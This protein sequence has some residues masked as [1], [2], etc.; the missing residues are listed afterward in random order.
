MKISIDSKAFINREVKSEIKNYAV[1]AAFLILIGFLSFMFS[2]RVDILGIEIVSCVSVI[3]GILVF[4][5]GSIYCSRRKDAFRKYLE[6]FSFAVEGAAKEAL[7]SF[8]DP[9]VIIS[10]DGVIQWCNKKFT[11]LCKEENI[12]GENIKRLLPSVRIETFVEDNIPVQDFSYDGR[13][14]ILNGTVSE[15]VFDGLGTKMIGISFEDIS[16]ITNLQK[17]IDDKRT[18]VCVASIDNYDEVL[19]ETPNSNHG[20]LLGDIERCVSLWVEKGGGIYRHYERDKYMI[21]FEAAKFDVLYKEK[22]T[23]LNEVKEINQQNKIPVTL[24]M[25]ISNVSDDIRENDRIAL[26]ALDMALGR[27]GDQVVMKTENGYSFF[28]AKSL[29]VE[30]ATKVKARIVAQRL[31]DLMDK[32]SNVIIM[33]HKGADYDSFGAAVGLF[34]AAREHGKAAYIAMDKNKNN[35]GGI[36]P[37]ILMHRTIAEGIVGLDKATAVADSD[38]LIIIVDTHRESMVEYSELFRFS[39]NIV[40]IDH[41]RRSED[42]M[43]NTVLTYHEPYASSTCEMVT[44]I[45][46]Y[47]D[48]AHDITVYEAEAMYCGIYM[49]TKAFKFKTGARTFEAAAYLRKA[50]VDP[51]R[52]HTLFRNDISMYIQKSKV[53]SNAKIYRNNIA[54]AVCDEQ[55]KNLQLV[56]AQAADDLL[57]IKGVEASFVLAAAGQRIIISGRSLGAV[58]VQV[59]LEKL[60]GGGHITI[61]GAQLE[62]NSLTIA[63][64][65]L[66]NAIDEALFE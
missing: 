61:A 15:E 42:F 3:S 63:E 66:H 50:G 23:V 65:K 7:L 33:G 44:E 6:S 51:V 4:V 47:M 35:I 1:C 10:E 24:S 18:V 8:P 54:I 37:D 12:I 49:D 38:S 13:D 21:M 36:L 52:V 9:M 39:E 45:L 58:N 29:G 57:N 55:S 20:V 46:Q 30:K 32:A 64:M 31:S 34:R 11:V 56:V 16:D 25:G 59:I 60:G 27:G 48:C 19:K 22:F 41:H 40:L 62:N 14:F 5:F 28:G 43:E 53:I 17:K 26:G 2:M